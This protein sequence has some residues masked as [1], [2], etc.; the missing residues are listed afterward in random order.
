MELLS[1]LKKTKK[2]QYKQMHGKE[3]NM[4]SITIVHEHKLIPEYYEDEEGNK[5]EKVEIRYLAF[6][7]WTNDEEKHSLFYK[8]TTALAW[9]EL[10]AAYEL[11]IQHYARKGKLK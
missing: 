4:G 8:Y 10:Q 9:L 1:V 11:L 2:D 5:K 7:N 6:S 3:I